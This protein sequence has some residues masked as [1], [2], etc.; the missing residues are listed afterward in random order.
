MPFIRVTLVITSLGALIQCY[1]FV[2]MFNYNV[3]MQYSTGCLAALYVRTQAFIF[4]LNETYKNMVGV[5]DARDM[6]SWI[7]TCYRN[8]YSSERVVQHS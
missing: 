7:S 4:L 1:Y 6:H 3:L 2:K 8:A 5:D